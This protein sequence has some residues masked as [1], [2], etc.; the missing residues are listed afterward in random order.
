M[1]NQTVINEWCIFKAYKSKIM[2][3][4]FIKV[5]GKIYGYSYNNDSEEMK[6]ALFYRNNYKSLELS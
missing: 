1:E 5:V 6:W 3:H 4:S 2:K